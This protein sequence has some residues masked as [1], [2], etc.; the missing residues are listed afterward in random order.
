LGA[1]ESWRI[2]SNGIPRH[3]YIVGCGRCINGVLIY[4]EAYIDVGVDHPHCLIMSFDVRSENFKP[5]KLPEDYSCLASH[6][7]VLVPYEG[8]LAIVNT[9]NFSSTELWVF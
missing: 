2:L 8:R 3:E 9:R 1:Q 6:M 7:I 5:I 4:Y